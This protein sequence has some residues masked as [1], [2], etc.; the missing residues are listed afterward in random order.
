MVGVGVASAVSADEDGSALSDGVAED[1]VCI[2]DF[3]CARG[4]SWMAGEQGCHGGF[5]DGI[6]LHDK[7]TPCKF[8]STVIN[9]DLRESQGEKFFFAKGRRFY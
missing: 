1:A 4:E 3:V 7:K 9:H 8:V 2:R 6:V 5:S